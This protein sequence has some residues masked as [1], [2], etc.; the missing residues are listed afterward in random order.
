MC[1]DLLDYFLYFFVS[2]PTSPHHRNFLDDFAKDSLTMY[3]PFENL[4]AGFVCLL[5]F[6]AECLL[7]N[8]D[9]F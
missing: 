9:H 1:D 7:K 8:S 6:Q 5:L 4:C 2:I 3:L